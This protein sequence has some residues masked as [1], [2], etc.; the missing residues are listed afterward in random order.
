MLRKLEVC[1]RSINAQ[2]EFV[3]EN[4]LGLGAVK[5]TESEVAQESSEAAVAGFDY[6]WVNFGRAINSQKTLL[7]QRADDAES[8]KTTNIM[9]GTFGVAKKNCLEDRDYGS[10]SGNNVRA[11][12]HGFGGERPTNLVSETLGDSLETCMD[13]CEGNSGWCFYIF[14]TPEENGNPTTCKQFATC[15]EEDGHLN[16]SEVSGLMLRKLT[17]VESATTAV[18]DMVEKSTSGFN[19][20][21]S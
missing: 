20:G 2:K 13:R 3:I 7:T 14:W 5:D 16:V 6:R 11:L 21:W 4:A 18:G 1:G 10:S 9:C 19:W 17:I 8:Y 12:Y 15:G